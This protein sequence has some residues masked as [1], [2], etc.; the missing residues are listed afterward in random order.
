VGDVEASA[1]LVLGEDFDDA[2]VE[3]DHRPGAEAYLE[4]V[5]IVVGGDLP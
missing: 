1:R 5:P 2:S 4:H 3:G